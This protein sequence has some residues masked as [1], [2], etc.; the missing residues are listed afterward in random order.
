MPPHEFCV[1]C[2]RTGR[3]L[4]DGV[5]AECAAERTSLVRIPEHV[6][7]VLCP[8]CGARRG[9]GRW[10]RAGASSVIAAEDLAP[11][12][13]LDPEAAVREVR[14]T[15]RGG[16]PSRRELHGTARIRFRGLERTVELEVVVRVV[17]QTCTD[18]GRRSGRYY[19]AIV[20]LRGEASP[21]TRRPKELRRRLDGVWQGLWEEFRGDWRSAVAWREERPEGW[22]VYF[23]DTLAARSV[24]RLARQRFGIPIVE[25]ASLFGR[26][27]GQDVYR[28]TF[29]LRFPG[30]DAR[31]PPGPER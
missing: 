14:W 16:T 26:R 5:C 29:C 18:C 10:S 6:Q 8:Q 19:T 28:V 15:E 2:G 27:N 1:V 31:T 17:G 13:V 20:Q 3:T 9:G 25:S 24:A 7:V 12:L 11:F 21:R 23:T 22:D 30:R 4:T